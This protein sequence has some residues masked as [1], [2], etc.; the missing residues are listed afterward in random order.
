MVVLVLRSPN[1]FFLMDFRMMLVCCLLFVVCRPLILVYL[2]RPMSIYAVLTAETSGLILM[3][4]DTRVYFD[5]ISN[6]IKKNIKKLKI[7][8]GI[9][10]HKIHIP[11]Y[12]KHT[13]QTREQIYRSSNVIN[14]YS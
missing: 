12:K 8:V 9:G 5:R 1:F 2:R 11:G 4:F 10:F 6:S 3:K 14:H 13:K 7:L